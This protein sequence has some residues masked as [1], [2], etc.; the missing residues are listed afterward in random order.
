[1]PSSSSPVLKP[2]R[3]AQRVFAR[4]TSKTGELFILAGG[5]RA[6]SPAELLSGDCFKTLTT[7]TAAQ[8]DRVIID[9]APVLAVSDTLLMAP[10]V[11]TTCMVVRAGKDAAQRDQSRVDTA[12]RRG[13]PSGRHCLEPSAAPSRFR[14]LLLLHVARIRRRHR[15]LHR[16]FGRHGGAGRPA[17]PPTARSGGAAARRRCYQL[18]LF[19]ISSCTARTRS[20][21]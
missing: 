12:C 14:L 6:P 5:Q 13:Q 19:V 21:L 9:S 11:Q 18:A 17:R 15:L 2:I 4:R 1:M 16:W 3:S 10:H 7:E 8:F 20:A